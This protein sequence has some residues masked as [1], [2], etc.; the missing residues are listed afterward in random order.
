MG[1]FWASIPQTT[2]KTKRSDLDAARMR[3]LQQLLAAMLNNA[4]FG[5]S[6]SGSI[7]IADAEAAYCGTDINA[8]K[9]AQAAMAAF[10]ESGDAGNFDPG[11]SA[12]PKTAKSIADEAF[13]N[14]LP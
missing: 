5:S 10:N 7:S 6:P 4:A 3:L 12:D 8:I 1:G 13:W 2:T 11:M 9:A 14:V